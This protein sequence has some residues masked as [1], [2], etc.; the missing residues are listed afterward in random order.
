MPLLNGPVAAGAYARHRREICQ[1]MRAY[2]GLRTLS[3]GPHMRLLF[4]DRLT[5][6]HLTLETMHVERFDPA[7]DAEAN[8]T[9]FAHLLPDGDSLC[10]TL[11]IQMEDDALR[12]QWLPALNEAVHEVFLEL[13]GQPSVRARVNE[14][15]DDQHLARP[16][17]VHFLRFHLPRP[18]RAALLD[19][20]AVR[21]CCRHAACDCRQALAPALLARLRADLRPG[22]WVEGLSTHRGLCVDHAASPSSC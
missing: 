19:G 21:L 5:V 22:A 13:Q 2:K 18:A 8:L 16:S 20:A 3:L 10:A 1:R 12:R 11:M 15:L 7:F 4:E 6:S 14:D 17:A 9:R